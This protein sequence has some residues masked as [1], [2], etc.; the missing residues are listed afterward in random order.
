MYQIHAMT[1]KFIATARF[2]ALVPHSSLN[3][4]N[5]GGLVLRPISTTSPVR[6]MCAQKSANR[7]QACRKKLPRY[8]IVD[9][10]KKPQIAV[11][12]PGIK[13]VGIN[14]SMD[15][16]DKILS[17]RGNRKLHD[18]CKFGSKFSQRFS[19]ESDVAAGKVSADITTGFLV[20]MAPKDFKPFEHSG[21]SIPVMLDDETA[22]NAG[23]V[24][25]KK[26][27]QDFCKSDF[28]A[29][30][31][32]KAASPRKRRHQGRCQE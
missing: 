25:S 24:D 14:V 21:H 18:S 12:V 22:D 28:G 2:A 6:S 32:C 20:V 1:M 26:G 23:T 3:A 15:K 10:E 11:D 4:G 13:L 29:T 30:V 19:L 8:D 5:I 16:V 9:D 17:I 7:N 31:N 27:T